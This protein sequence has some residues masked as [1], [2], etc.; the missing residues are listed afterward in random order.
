MLESKVNSIYQNKE[1]RK[2]ISSKDK[3]LVKIY[4]RITGI[5][6]NIIS[7]LQEQP[8]NNIFAFVL[9]N[10]IT[11]PKEVYIFKFNNSSTCH[12]NCADPKK[13]VHMVNLSKKVI[14]N[15]IG[16][17]FDIFMTECKPL[18]LYFLAR[19]NSQFSSKE[20]TSSEDDEN[21]SHAIYISKPN[22]KFRLKAPSTFRKSLRQH[23]KE[24]TKII[25]MKVPKLFIIELSDH[26]MTNTETSQSKQEIESFLKFNIAF[27]TNTIGST[28]SQ[29]KDTEE[30]CWFLFK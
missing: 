21:N 1:D 28:S 6:D 20:Q 11:N 29:T 7:I 27:Q 22:F 17:C 9:G 18:P 3:K 19:L 15:I 4:E 13:H 5:I 26:E 12:M 24:G 14:R 25:D 23:K 2:R 8:E 16:G 30:D 10:S